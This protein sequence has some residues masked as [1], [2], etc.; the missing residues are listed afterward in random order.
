M[1]G[2]HKKAHTKAMVLQAVADAQGEIKSGAV[3]EIVGLK[4]ATAGLHLLQLH[5]ERIVLRRETA[6][7][8]GYAYWINPN[9]PATDEAVLDEWFFAEG[10][11]EA[12]AAARPHWRKGELFPPSKKESRLTN[13]PSCGIL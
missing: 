1:G 8:G 5:K 11:G 4:Q 2:K 7:K 13:G 9:P 6:A 12:I 10:F 3:A